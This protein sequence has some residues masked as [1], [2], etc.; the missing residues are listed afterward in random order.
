MKYN[1]SQQVIV[2]PL[3]KA[4]DLIGWLDI[5]IRACIIL[6]TFFQMAPR[7]AV[8]LHQC[9]RY[10]RYR[11]VILDLQTVENAT[12][13]MRIQCFV[14]RRDEMRRK[15]ESNLEFEDMPK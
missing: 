12:W 13:A 9:Q 4:L 14:M 10:D 6:T 1:L 15:E 5:F 7:E 3:V 2:A 11:D 8:A